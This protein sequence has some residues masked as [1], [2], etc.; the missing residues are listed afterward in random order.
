MQVQKLISL[1]LISET[2]ALDVLILYDFRRIKR[3]KLYTVA[4]IIEA[5]IEKY[6]V[7]KYRVEKII[8]HKKQKRY[9]C[10]KCA[11]EI[12]NRERRRGNGKCDHC[13]ALE[14]EI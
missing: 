11:K 8:Y 9:F 1:G 6:K 4:Q 7:S 14:I 5:L 3:R 10:D 2:R 13:V 12:T